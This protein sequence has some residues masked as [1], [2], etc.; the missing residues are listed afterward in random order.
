MRNQC[1]NNMRV[2]QSS[3]RQSDSYGPV[4]Q[5]GERT[6][7]I[8]KVDGSIPFRSTIN[9]KWYRCHWRKASGI[10]RFRAFSARIFT[11]DFIDVNRRFHL[12]GGI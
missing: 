2:C 6:V 4:A 1:Y 5:L 8:R 11:D 7:R 9:S 12:T 10:N 3:L